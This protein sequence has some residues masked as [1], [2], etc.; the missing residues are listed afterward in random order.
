MRLIRSGMAAGG[1]MK[2]SLYSRCWVMMTASS[3][4][5]ARTSP[6]R[7]LTL[8]QLIPQVSS[9]G[10]RLIPPEITG[11]NEAVHF[12]R[13]SRLESQL[14]RTR[15]RWINSLSRAHTASRA[16]PGEGRQNPRHYGETQS[17]LS[18][19]GWNNS[20]LDKWYNLSHTGPS[21]VGLFL[22]LGGI[23]KRE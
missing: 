2:L 12:I 14:D 18:W 22:A 17:K 15:G 11:W 21:R 13:A 1:E 6:P 10:R 8:T 23:W 20:K 9:R 7:F 4:S 3:L 5:S 19:H 16:S